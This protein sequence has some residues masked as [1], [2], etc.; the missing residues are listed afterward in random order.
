VCYGQ[1]LGR[2]SNRDMQQTTKLQ[3][4][5]AIACSC[6]NMPNCTFQPYIH[7]RNDALIMQERTL[8]LAK[9]T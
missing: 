1:K 7:N 9:P 6:D 2:D 8:R 4:P 3:E 5:H